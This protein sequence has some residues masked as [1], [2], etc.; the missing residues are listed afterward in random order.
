[1]KTDKASRHSNK[2]AGTQA[3]P[4]ARVMPSARQGN[5]PDRKL[6]LFS[7]TERT[8]KLQGFNFFAHEADNGS[9]GRDQS[10]VAGECNNRAHI[11]RIEKIRKRR[12]FQRSDMLER[13][14][15]TSN[16][17]SKQTPITSTR[18]RIK[19]IETNIKSPRSSNTAVSNKFAY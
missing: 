11:S 9:K 2:Q 1:M 7:D 19:D 13:V 14:Q 5:G 3:R 16:T 17:K 12:A 4:S 6:S 18:Y 10:R 15:Q 8:N